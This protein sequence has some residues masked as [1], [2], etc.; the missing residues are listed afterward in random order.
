MIAHIEGILDSRSDESIVID[1]NGVGYEIFIP[2][3]LFEQLPE[4]GSRCKIFVHTHFR[5]E[6]GFTLYGF[7]ALEDKEFF[8]LLIKTVS[9]IGPKVAL[10]IMSSISVPDLAEAIVS[11]D[12]KTLTR[13]NGI[14]KKTAQ[15]L[16]VELKDKVAEMC[17]LK[18][19]KRLKADDVSD[20]AI[21]ALIALGYSRQVAT[22]AVLKGRE[23]FAAM[24]KV[25]D[26]IKV[27][28]RYL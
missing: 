28:L 12:L 18:H 15:R 13:V 22:S 1:V 16:I 6:D 24:P 8:Q 4:E 26:L 27:S 5:E 10:S 19:E 7:T 17:L 20:D 3:H 23:T 21:D 11:E 25:E 2:S 14:G 9:G